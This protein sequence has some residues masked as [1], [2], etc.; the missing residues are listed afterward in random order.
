MRGATQ[1]ERPQQTSGL[2]AGLRHAASPP[3]QAP[4]WSGQPSHSP[5]QSRPKSWP[6][7]ARQNPGLGKHGYPESAAKHH[8]VL[9]LR[10]CPGQEQAPRAGGGRLADEAEGWSR[11]GA[12]IVRADEHASPRADTRILVYLGQFRRR[13]EAPGGRR[14]DCSIRSL[15]APC[16]ARAR[17]HLP[18][19]RNGSSWRLD[20]LRFRLNVVLWPVA[21][22]C[23]QGSLWSVERPETSPSS[24]SRWLA[25]RCFL[26]YR[27][28]NAVETRATIARYGWAS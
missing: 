15:R 19:E 7:R 11:D 18:R 24:A 13:S 26:T 25:A 28:R 12:A 1:Q 17:Q 4:H 23:G 5:P 8:L 9:L 27:F 21:V 10:P 16:G 14:A 2:A 6:D 22:T 20:G 3:E